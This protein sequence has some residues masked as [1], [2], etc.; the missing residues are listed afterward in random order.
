[1]G[2]P[3]G[4][5]EVKRVDA[6]YRP[7]EERIEDYSE[8]EQQLPLE[9][10]KLQ[11][12]RCMDC[13]VPFCHWACPVSNNMPEWQDAI[14]RD[15]WQ[16]AY[17]MLSETNNFP[18]FTGRVCP[19]LCEASCVLSLNDDAV[20]I[21]NNEL[22][23]IE[24]AFAE[25]YV[26]PEPPKT[27]SGKKVAVVGSGPAGLAC[28]DLLNKAGH[29][30]EL[31]EAEKEVGGFIR[32]GIPDFKLEK[33]IIDRRVKILTDE[34]LIIK[35]GVKVGEDLSVDDLKKNYDAVV[36]TIGA[37]QPRDL[38]AEGRDL[39]GI[40]FAYDYLSQQNKIIAGEKFENGDLIK[41]YDKK[42]L[43]IGGGDT[44]SDCVGTANRQGAI[45][46]TQVELMPMPPKERTENEPWPLWPRLHKTSSSHNEGC[47]RIWNVLTKKIVGENG[48]VKKVE[49]CKVEWTKD[50]NGRF[51]M[52][53]VPGSDF[54]IEAD[55]IFL[56][57]GFVHPEHKGLV[58]DLGLELDGRGNIKVDENYKT[59]VDK[60][61][62]A[63]D[64]KRG[65][66]LI[67]WAINEGRE[68]AMAV[69]DFL[70]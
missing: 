16:K 35:T 32:Y 9:D 21:R 30:V 5:L 37:R 6:G 61:F 1:M 42:V 62:A 38:Q 58:E 12:S 33:T 53:E 50:E 55:L 4:F 23:V 43:V 56:A 15:D 45:S 69:N 66:S 22:S 24:K 28:A 27:R 10:R 13:G 7:V 3:K 8:V 20:T 63:G 14:F 67:V 17:D 18:E 59:N 60:V 68:A 2:N 49:A 34:G 54:T 36:V 29:T 51:N 41:A 48:E 11:A 52:K 40:H 44:G 57:M 25:G 65:A 39:K 70:K 26:K 19:A 64:S 47:E 31:Y 46:V